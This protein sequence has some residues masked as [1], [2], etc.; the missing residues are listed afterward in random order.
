MGEMRR[1]KKE[2][3]VT[4]VKIEERERRFSESWERELKGFG[5]RGKR[6]KM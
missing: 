5:Y 1:K 6:K 2:V 4:E 3:L